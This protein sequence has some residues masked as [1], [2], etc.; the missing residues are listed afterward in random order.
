MNQYAK[1]NPDPTPAEIQERAAIIR[2]N[3]ELGMQGH[4]D[5]VPINKLRE[6]AVRKKTLRDLIGERIAAHDNMLKEREIQEELVEE[7]QHLVPESWRP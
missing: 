5:N 1:K 2:A 3:R 4:K 6:V 7:P